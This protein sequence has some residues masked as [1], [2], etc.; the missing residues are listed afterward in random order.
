MDDLLP[1]MNTMAVLGYHLCLVSLPHPDRPDGHVWSAE[2]A[3]EPT[4]P[5]YRHGCGT[6]GMA[7]MCAACRLFKKDPETARVWARVSMGGHIKERSRGL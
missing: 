6:P 1:L 4:V 2:F 7:V 5:A 3:L